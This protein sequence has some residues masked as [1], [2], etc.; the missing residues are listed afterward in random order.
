MT[1]EQNQRGLD[2]FDETAS[3]VRGFPNAMLGYDK[4]AVDDYIQDMERQLAGAKHQLREVQ[5]ELTAA[6]LR[7]DDTDFGRLG[8]HTANL[9]KVAEAQSADLVHQAKVRADRIVN[10]AQ[11]TADRVRLEAAAVSETARK[12]GVA[13][14]KGLR[15]D[16]EAQTTSEL[17][18]AR[19]EA[20]S[21]RQEADAHRKS[22]MDDAAAQVAAMRETAHAELEALH[23]QAATDAA[24]AR[25]EVE[26]ERA[27]TLKAVADQHRER[28]EAVTA[29]SEQHRAASAERVKALETAAEDLRSRQQAAHAEAENIK[30]AAHTEAG[31]IVSEARTQAEELLARTDAELQTRGE[32]LKNDIKTLRQRK[33]ALLSQLAQLSTMAT[34]TANEFP[35]DDQTAPVLQ[36][37]ADLRAPADAA[38]A[39]G[40]DEPVQDSDGSTGGLPA[41]GENA[42]VP[43]GE[44][45]A[46]VG[47]GNEQY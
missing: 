1:E 36:A 38:I 40:V 13:S 46:S 26:R 25:A 37:L 27:E 16:L 20:D 47:P 23:Q 34:E 45:G 43:E 41:D 9:L 5:R 35:E 12:E 18:A 15:A 4:K 32:Q 19:A 6:N 11:A 2:L 24:A 39:G 30:S 21:I 10:D 3:A 7:V 29:L 28:L 14:L 44:S 22:V 33:Q 31:T 8:A 42:E 17:D